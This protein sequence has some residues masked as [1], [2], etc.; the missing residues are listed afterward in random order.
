MKKIIIIFSLFIIGELVVA[1]QAGEEGSNFTLK[2]AQEY[3]VKNNYSILNANRDVVAAKKK[4]WE[5]IAIG[6]PQITSEATFQNFIELPTSL[7]PANSFNPNA[8]AGE[9]AELQFGTGFSFY[10]IIH[11]YQCPRD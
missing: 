7:M 2:Q 5:T 11:S 8:P 10:P 6:L 1:Q 3:A 9:F 4:A